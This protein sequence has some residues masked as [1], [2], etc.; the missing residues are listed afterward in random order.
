MPGRRPFSELT[1]DWSPERRARF[2]ADLKDQTAKLKAEPGQGKSAYAYPVP[3]E[4]IDRLAPAA[5]RAFE[6]IAIHLDLS[7][8]EK[9]AL[10][11]LAETDDMPEAS[12]V[13]EHQFYRLSYLVGIWLDIGAVF[14]ATDRIVHWL[15]VPVHNEE[16]GGR[17]C[18]DYLIGEGLPGFDRVRREASYWANNGW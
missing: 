13:T 7:L 6:R 15:R 1:K 3:R 12:A 17:S 9:R 5:L 4:E 18:V 10:L 11:G 2:E 16:F 14:G 8:S